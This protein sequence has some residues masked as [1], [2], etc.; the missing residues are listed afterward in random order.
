[1]Y[2]GE[3]ALLENAKLLELFYLYCK[4]IKAQFGVNPSEIAMA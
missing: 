2:E 1:M 3:Y 4:T